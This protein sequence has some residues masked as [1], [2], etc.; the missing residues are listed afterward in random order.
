MNPTCPPE[1]SEDARAKWAELIA[2]LGDALT[3]LDLDAIREYA[4]AF[5]EEQEA[6]RLLKSCPNPFIVAGDGAPYQN[7]LRAIVNK[8]RDQMTRSGNCGTPEI[9]C[10]TQVHS[11]FVQGLE[12]AGRA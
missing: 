1:L 9:Q 3:P 10:G 4:V 6:L 5:A 11:G 12:G 2:D 8:A 7:P